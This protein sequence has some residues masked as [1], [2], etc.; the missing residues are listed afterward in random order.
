MIFLIEIFSDPATRP[1]HNPEVSAAEQA[2]HPQHWGGSAWG[3]LWWSIRQWLL[4]KID[5]SKQCEENYENEAKDQIR[6]QK[7]RWCGKCWSRFLGPGSENLSRW[8]FLKS[9]L[10]I[11]LIFLIILI[12]VIILWRLEVTSISSHC[13]TPTVS[14]TM[15]ISLIGR[16][17][18]M[19][20]VTTKMI[21][22]ATTMMVKMMVMVKLLL[23]GT[24][25]LSTPSSTSTGGFFSPLFWFLSSRLPELF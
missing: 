12:T 5:K 11:I 13:V 17:V 15:S 24:R 4:R 10:L 9:I 21:I 6:S 2:S 1:V 19:L 23:T 20:T 25:D 8:F 3:R 16:L 18:L 14:S 22:I 7:L